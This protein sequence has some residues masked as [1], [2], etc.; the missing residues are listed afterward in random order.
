M[1]ANAKITKIAPLAFSS[2]KVGDRLVASGQAGADGSSFTA[3][4]IA[5]N[6]NTGGGMGGPGG[7]GGFGG[8]GGGRGGFGGPGGGPGGQGGPGGGGPGGQG[9]QG[10]DPGGPPPPD[11]Q[12]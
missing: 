11:G 3:T 7:F 9:G 5:V 2:L 6:M 4:G 10:G 1:A 12:N 8:P